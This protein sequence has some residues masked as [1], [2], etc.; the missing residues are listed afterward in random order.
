MLP[1]PGGVDAD[2]RN[3]GSDHD[4][5]IRELELQIDA[6][7]GMPS[8][9]TGN[10]APSPIRIVQTPV[11]SFSVS[12]CLNFSLFVMIHLIGMEFENTRV[13][14]VVALQTIPC[15]GFIVRG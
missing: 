7:Y 11:V 12:T 15:C 5:G 14:A 4:T 8:N 13:S 9:A 1:T 3:S 2:G 6:L 10:T